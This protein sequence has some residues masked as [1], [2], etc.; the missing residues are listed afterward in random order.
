MIPGRFIA[1]EGVDGSGKSTV[2]QLVAVALRRCGRDV[3]NTREPGGCPGAEELRRLLV[4]GEP[5]R[6]SPMAELLLHTAARVEHYHQTILPAVFSGSWVLCDRFLGSSVA[7][8]GYGQFL[9]GDV[10]MRLQE[11]ANVGMPSLTVV[12]EVPPEVAAARLAGRAAGGED[13][14]HQMGDDFMRHVRSGY[15]AMLE[16][17][18]FKAVGVDASGAPESVAAAVV[19]LIAERFRLP[20]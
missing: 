4:E 1:F 12:L 3:L 2:M 17:P 8:Q 9:G 18:D 13:R 6:W 10:V 16:D 19:G 5:G 7:Y 15:R 14:H 11:L 20:E